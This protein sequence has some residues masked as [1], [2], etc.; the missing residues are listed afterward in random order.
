MVYTLLSGPM[1]YTVFPCFPKE[2]VYTTIAFFVSVT[3]GLGDR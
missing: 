2:M 1:V 3:S